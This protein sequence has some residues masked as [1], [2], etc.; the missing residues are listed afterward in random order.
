MDRN[1]E[2]NGVADTLSNRIGHR[3]QLIRMVV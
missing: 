1:V 3:M 2:N